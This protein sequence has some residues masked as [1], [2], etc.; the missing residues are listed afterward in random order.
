MATKKTTKARTAAK[1]KPKEEPLAEFRKAS[2][3]TKAELG[4]LR[5]EDLWILKPAKG[6]KLRARFCGC[7]NIC[8]V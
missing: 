3:L 4:R 5:I 8:I 7:R 6:G 2:T 1:A